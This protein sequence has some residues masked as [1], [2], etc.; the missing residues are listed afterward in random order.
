VCFWITTRSILA[1]SWAPLADIGPIRVKEEPFKF[2]SLRGNQHDMRSSP[3]WAALLI[4]LAFSFIGLGCGDQ[5]DRPELGYVKGTVTMDGKPLAGVI[6]NFKPEVGRAATATTDDDGNYDLIY[7]YGV[8]GAKIGPNIINVEWP[9][10]EAGQPIP[11][12]YGTKT[13]LK[14]EVEAGNNTFD[15]DLSSK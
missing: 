13:T 1:N 12:K 5:G 11:E 15:F 10:G 14:E 9:T 4:L 8:R 3:K 6:I 2:G 7:R